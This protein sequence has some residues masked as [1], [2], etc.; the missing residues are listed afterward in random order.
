MASLPHNSQSQGIEVAQLPQ[1]ALRKLSMAP[2]ASDNMADAAQATAMEHSMTLKQA[3][4]VYRKAVSPTTH[5]PRPILF[6][7]HCRA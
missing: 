4:T 2:H 7:S 5:S 1:D 6:H 3:F